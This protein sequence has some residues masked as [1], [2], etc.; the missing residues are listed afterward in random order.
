MDETR[1]RNQAKK[2]TIVLG[3]IIHREGR[4][5]R[6]LKGAREDHRIRFGSGKIEIMISSPRGSC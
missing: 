1:V 6:N 2:F 3:N 5:L 4:G